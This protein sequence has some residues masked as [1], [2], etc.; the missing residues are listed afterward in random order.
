MFFALWKKN[1]AEK[2]TKGWQ[3]GCLLKN[4]KPYKCS[5]MMVSVHVCSPIRTR[6]STINCPHQTPPDTTTCI[7]TTA[8]KLGNNYKYH[9]LDWSPNN[10]MHYV[11]IIFLSLYEQSFFLIAVPARSDFIWTIHLTVLFQQDVHCHLKV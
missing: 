4:E 10:A 11:V 8:L 1:N 7:L 6:P 3:K 2:K 9:W 5:V